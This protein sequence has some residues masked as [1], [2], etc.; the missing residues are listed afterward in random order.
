M[1]KAALEM[2]LE[3]VKKDRSMRPALRLFAEAGY[4]IVKMTSSKKLRTM[5][6]LSNAFLLI[7]PQ[8][9]PH[10]ASGKAFV[11]HHRDLNT[12]NIL[13]DPT[14]YR[15]TGIVDWEMTRLAPTWMASVHLVFL[16]DIDFMISDE[17]EPPILSYEHEHDEGIDDEVE[18]AIMER[19]CW[20]SEHLR[21]H[22]IV[23]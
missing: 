10:E 9:C 15:V 13:V 22:F 2:Q 4:S 16:Q 12:G 19:D 17:A 5:E 3:C 21:N 23:Q 18:V 6:A 8:V 7:L 20:E 1:L 14:S 11:L